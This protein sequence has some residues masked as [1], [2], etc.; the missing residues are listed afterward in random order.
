MNRKIRT[1]LL[2]AGFVVVTNPFAS[3]SLPGTASP[4][5]PIVLK[6]S[7]LRS[8]YLL[9]A[10]VVQYDRTAMSR[11]GVRRQI[12]R[13]FDVVLGLL[14]VTTPRSIETTLDRLEASADTNWTVQE[15]AKWR[16]Q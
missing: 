2:I 10:G 1:G 11:D 14:L 4:S 13:H 12:Q 5:Q 16:A 7:D 9:R 3:A 8:A 15:R 6:I